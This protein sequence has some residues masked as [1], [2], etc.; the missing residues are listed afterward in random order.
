[1][2]GAA[3]TVA[4]A[5]VVSAVVFQSAVVVVL[6][7]VADVEMAVAVSA[8]EMFVIGVLVVPDVAVAVV[9]AGPQALL[10]T[11]ARGHCFVVD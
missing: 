9:V 7:S 4:D 2:F 11:F 10:I 3:V 8:A 1:M 6:Y 5:V